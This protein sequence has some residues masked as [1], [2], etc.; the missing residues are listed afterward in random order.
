MRLSRDRWV[1]VIRFSKPT[2]D[3]VRE[4]LESQRSA[5]FSYTQLG[6]TRLGP[7]FGYSVDRKRTRLGT[8]MDDFQTASQAIRGWNM[9]DLGWVD[10]ADR[11]CPIETGRDVGVAA[12][13]GPAWVLAACRIVEVIDEPGRRF[14]FAYGT[15][16]DH[17]ERGEERFLI[18]RDAQDAIWYELLAISR[19]ARWYVRLLS[20]FARWLQRRFRNDSAAAMVR[21][22]R[23]AIA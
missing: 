14:G 12:Q 19:P 6:C 22:M 1:R 3:R 8:G 18:E 15:L 17:V 9:F 11:T 2:P 16:E 13:I 7:P 5:S 20:P 21:A 10:V 23:S 4:F